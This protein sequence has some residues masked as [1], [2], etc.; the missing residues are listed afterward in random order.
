MGDIRGYRK[1]CRNYS[2]T[3]EVRRPFMRK[4]H[5]LVTEFCKKW[6]GR[7]TRMGD[8]FVIFL[9]IPPKRTKTICIFKIL[10]ATKELTSKLLRH[11]SLASWPRPGGFRIRV[12]G[13]WV[14]RELM[15][16][17]NHPG[18]KLKIPEYM[19]EAPNLA[20]EMQYVHPEVPFL[21]HSSVIRRLSQAQIDELGA[22]PFV[23]TEKVRGIVP[24]E[25]NEIWEIPVKE[26]ERR[27]K[28]RLA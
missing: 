23:V 7:L 11:N 2:T 26:E 6:N 21:S 22:K 5:K 17:F 9:E 28:R 19:G 14:D 15:E 24:E 1:W 12:P 10:L 3:Q 4:F 13:G 27:A 8:G 25:L 20:R 18:K 16:D